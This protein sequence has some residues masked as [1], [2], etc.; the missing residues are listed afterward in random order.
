MLLIVVLVATAIM[1][2]VMTLHFARPLSVRH[3]R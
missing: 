2:F 3:R 1:L